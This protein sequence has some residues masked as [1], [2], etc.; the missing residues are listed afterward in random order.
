MSELNIPSWLVR[1]TDQLNAQDLEGAPVVAK[2]EKVIVKQSK[3]QPLEIFL[4]GY[5]LCYRPCLSMRSVLAQAWGKQEQ[6][7]VG[8][9]I[10]IFC[11]SKV[12]F[13]DQKNIGGIR[14]DGLSDFPEGKTFVITVAR[15]RKQVWPVR[16]LQSQTGTPQAG[17]SAY[18]IE[19]V[20]ENSAAWRGLIDSGK[21]TQDELLSVLK[22]KFH[23]SP[24]VEQAFFDETRV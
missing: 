7:W 14:I 12:S 11:D 4:A 8:K 21:K 1:K 24:E 5:P 19:Q 3:D 6:T 16:L 23:L 22:S 10:S 17:K 18:T 13:G 15:G 2:I 9:T 20:K